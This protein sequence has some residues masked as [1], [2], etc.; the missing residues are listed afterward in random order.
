[1]NLFNII[2]DRCSCPRDGFFFFFFFFFFFILYLP[3]A[4][5]LNLI[6]LG[7]SKQKFSDF[8]IEREMAFAQEFIENHLSYFKKRKEIEEIEKG[9]GGGGGGG[10][11]GG[12]GRLLGGGFHIFEHVIFFHFETIKTLDFGRNCLALSALVGGVV[13][14]VM[15]GGGEV[16]RA[17]VGG[18]VEGKDVGFFLS[19]L[20]KLGKNLH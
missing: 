12:W 18:G 7:K 5:F 10:G 20:G 11:E 8:L 6:S 2:A 1:M 17:G 9:G 19:T 4:L 3:F 13:G 14:E 15:K 16:T